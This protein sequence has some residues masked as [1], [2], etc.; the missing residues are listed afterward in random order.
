MP[1]VK[2]VWLSDYPNKVPH[3]ENLCGSFWWRITLEEFLQLGI[4]KGHFSI[5]FK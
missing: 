3:A 5:F 4:A 1:W 2:L